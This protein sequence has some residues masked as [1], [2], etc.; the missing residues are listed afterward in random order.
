MDFKE[1]LYVLKIA[2]TKNITRAAEELFISQPALSHFLSKTERELGAKLFDRAASPLALTLSGEAYVRAAKKILAVSHN[3]HEELK[4]IESLK[5][6]HITLGIPP[7]RAAAVLPHVAAPLKEKYP[8]L[9]LETLERASDILLAAVRS[10]QADFA[11]LPADKMED[12]LEGEILCEEELFMV[13]L[14]GSVPEAAVK[15]GRI[16]DFEAL[17]A[18]APLPFVLLKKNHGIRRTCDTI[19][20]EFG[21]AVKVAFETSS[22]ETALRLAAA[23]LGVAI[24]P[25]ATLY[26]AAFPQR[27][28]LYHLS[29]RGM[30]WPLAMIHRKGEY[31]SDLKLFIA[32]LMQDGLEKE[33]AALNERIAAREK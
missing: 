29:A 15:D 6:G 20:R 31:L 5:S 8:T 13:G 30:K 23:G 25:A 18:L 33:N 27:L 14:E 2:E 4:D 11:L 12:D 17:A 21:L 26:T 3:L 1:L 7:S 22:N 28:Q 10:G 24:V 16:I 32:D 19:F 9:T